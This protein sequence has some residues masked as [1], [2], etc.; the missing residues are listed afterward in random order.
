MA[1]RVGFSSVIGSVHA[2]ELFFDPKR[3]IPE[4]WLPRGRW[5]SGRAAALHTFCDDYRQEFFWRRPEEGLLVAL[6]AGTCTAPD[7]TVWTDDPAQWAQFQVWRSASVA[8]FWQRHGVD[9][10][11][12]VS[13]GGR[14]E[15]W[16]QAGSAW[17]VRGPSGG[18][19]E[20]ERWWEQLAQWE[21]F[22]FPGLLVVFGR[23]VPA[24]VVSC[25]VVHRALF[26][27]SYEQRAAQKEGQL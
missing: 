12:V 7:F 17:A 15:Q 5:Q 13:F 2:E 3:D 21:A 19:E 24:G 20:V 26:S 10:L 6:A 8:A 9:V 11:P 25:P 4:H 22:A 14:V 27:R 18:P 1:R 23:M 16:V